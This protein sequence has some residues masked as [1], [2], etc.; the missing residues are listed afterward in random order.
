MSLTLLLGGRKVGVGVGMS[1]FSFHSLW[2]LSG[3]PKWLVRAL[4]QRLP[5][6]TILPLCR[7]AISYP[8][9]NCV[10]RAFSSLSY[11]FLIPSKAPLSPPQESRTLGPQL[12][13]PQPAPL[14]CDSTEPF[15]STFSGMKASYWGCPSSPGDKLI[16]NKSSFPE[17]LP[18]SKIWEG[19]FTVCQT[20]WF[21]FP[22]STVVTRK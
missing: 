22:F 8:V 17:I 11:I 18:P 2:H 19:Q 6:N 16:Y 1:S 13:I 15:S 9:Q 3:A 20:F 12:S 21:P 14:S 4:L 7:V 10:F 5:A